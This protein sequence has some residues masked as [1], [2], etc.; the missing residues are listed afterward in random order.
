MQTLDEFATA[1]LRDLAARDLRRELVETARVDGVWMERNG[2]RLLSFSCNDYLN[3]SQ[4][5]AV[6]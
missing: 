5:P 6:C 4:H 1:K 3:L 2:R